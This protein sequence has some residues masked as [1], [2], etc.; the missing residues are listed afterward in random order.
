MT[1]NKAETAGVCLHIEMWGAEVWILMRR[2]P[3]ELSRLRKGNKFKLCWFIWISTACSRA[4]LVGQSQYRGGR[5]GKK[6]KLHSVAL[7]HASAA[8]TFAFRLWQCYSFT[9]WLLAP[10]IW[11]CFP[12][13]LFQSMPS[14]QNPLYLFHSPHSNIR[15]PQVLWTGVPRE[16]MGPRS[17]I[18]LWR[19]LLQD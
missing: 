14:S 10:S 2:V 6:M 9:V 15:P 3:G 17:K 7:N 18:D 8:R 4:P 11:W 1:T 5:N 13:V 12:F 16:N 19:C